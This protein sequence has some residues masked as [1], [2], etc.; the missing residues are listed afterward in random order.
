MPS[1]LHWFFPAKFPFVSVRQ[2][3]DIIEFRATVQPLF[4]VIF[5]LHKRVRV[6]LQ[7]IWISQHVRP[8]DATQA[9][10]Q[11]SKRADGE[12]EGA[13]KSFAR[14]AFSFTPC[15]PPFRPNYYDGGV[16]P[17]PLPSSSLLSTVGGASNERMMIN[18]ERKNAPSLAFGLGARRMYKLP[19]L[20]GC[21]SNF[22]VPRA[23]L[24][25]D[26]NDK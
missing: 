1:L 13:K 14:A 24:L 10:R 6:L 18:F 25:C 12:E 17:L 9:S 19:L 26:M 16:K 15:L 22:F 11:T 23:R 4:Y 8:P 5:C 7:L 3:L 2:T 20:P 21:A